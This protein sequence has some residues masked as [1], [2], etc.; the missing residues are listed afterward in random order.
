[1]NFVAFL[2]FAVCDLLYLT[3]IRSSI[4]LLHVLDMQIPVFD[5]ALRYAY[6]AIFGDHLVVQRE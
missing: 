1:M 2:N 6:S 4:G 3:H 5:R